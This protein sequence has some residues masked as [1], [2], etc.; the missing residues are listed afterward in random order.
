VAARRHDG[1]ERAGRE[2]RAG[3]GGELNRVVLGALLCCA[4]ACSG[5]DSGGAP[6]TVPSASPPP[7]AVDGDWAL[8]GR[9][10]SEQRYSP[11]AQID[12]HN[13]AQLGLAWRYAT[14]TR[15]GL[16]A[17]PIVADGVLYATGSWSIVFALDAK[18]G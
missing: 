15:R 18:D 7:A 8:H 9:T 14:D 13:V 4:L 12:D 11:L 6:D 3:R 1:G 5:R 10:A 17:T 2:G 16:E